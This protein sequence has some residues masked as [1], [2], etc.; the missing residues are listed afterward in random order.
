MRAELRREY[1][2]AGE[3]VALARAL[4]P[5]DEAYVRSEARGPTLLLSVEAKTVGE[6]RRT[7][8]DALSCLSAAERTWERQVPT[9]GEEGEEE[10]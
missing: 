3:A 10:E 9:E 7:L 6:L 8:E 4:T 1:R 2:S 5:D